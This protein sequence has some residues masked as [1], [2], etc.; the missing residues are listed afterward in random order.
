MIL[1]NLAFIRISVVAESSHQLPR[2]YMILDY[3]NPVGVPRYEQK[4]ANM[5]S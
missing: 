4:W 1:E 3:T 5:A 2:F